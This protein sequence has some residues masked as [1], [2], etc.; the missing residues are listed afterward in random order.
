MVGVV[1]TICGEAPTWRKWVTNGPRGDIRRTSV[2]RPAPDEIAAARKSAG[3]CHFRPL[4]I[5]RDQR[6]G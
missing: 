2:N 5:F 3:S 6:E 4:V 1:A